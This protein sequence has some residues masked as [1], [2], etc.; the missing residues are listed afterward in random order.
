MNLKNCKL[1]SHKGCLDG[2]TTAVLFLVC[3]GKRENI[4]FSNP[5]HNDVDEIVNNLI[6]EWE[7]PIIIC[8]LSVSK[9][10]AEKMT[11]RTDVVLL[12]HHKSAIPLTKYKWCHISEKNEQCGSMMFYNWLRS[13]SDIE[14]KE[15]LIP[16]ID[17]VKGADSYDRWTE[18][19]HAYNSLV[20]LHGILE[21]ELF[22]DRFIKNPSLELSLNESY[23]VNLENRKKENFIKR[24]KEEIVIL[25]KTIKNVH[26]RFAIVKTDKY[27]SLLADSILNDFLIDVDAVIM[28]GLK[29]ISLRS[30]KDGIVD[31]AEIAELNFGGGHIS[32]SGFALDGLFDG[33]FLEYVTKKIKW[34]K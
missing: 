11:F 17:L 4:I 10:M 33:G 23:I 2:S 27:Q 3:G 5:N 28:I 22:L 31:V 32:S 16:Y 7:N 34:E 30:K 29:S 1:I 24:K 26:C 19:R 21:Q 13:S 15:K 18:K 6:Q 20:A 9:E 8:D 25:S 14:N 12:D